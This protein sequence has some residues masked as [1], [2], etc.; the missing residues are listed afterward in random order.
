M[1]ESEVCTFTIPLG[2]DFTALAE[3]DPSSGGAFGGSAEYWEL[4]I[5]VWVPYVKATWA[6]LLSLGEPLG[7]AALA[8]GVDPSSVMAFGE[9]AEY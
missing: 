8:E 5:V 2:A 4:A 9:S 7:F 1:Y 6:R 3:A